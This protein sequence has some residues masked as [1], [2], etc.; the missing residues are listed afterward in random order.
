[1]ILAY[2]LLSLLKLALVCIIPLF[3]SFDSM[4]PD[5]VL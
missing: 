5:L 2:Q 4:P 3:V 1:M